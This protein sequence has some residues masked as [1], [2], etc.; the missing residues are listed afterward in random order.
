MQR[1]LLSGMFGFL[2]SVA[3]MRAA[4]GQESRP[5]T[6]EA[7]AVQQM[8]TRDPS[9]EYPKS[10]AAKEHLEQGKRA[11]GVGEYDKAIDSYTAAGLVDDAPLI[12]Y[13]L[14]QT[15]RAAKEYDKAIRQYR[16]FLDRGKP[17]AEVRALVD[18]HISTMKAELEHAASTAPPTG[19]V[20]D[21]PDG[22]APIDGI[23]PGPSDQD[24]TGGVWTSARKVA[25]GTGIV[26]GLAIGVGVV[27]GVQGR[28]YKDDAAQLCPSDP[29]SNAAEANALSDKSGDRARL[30]NISFGTGAALIVGATVVWFLGGPATHADGDH[31]VLVPQLGEGFTGLVYAQRF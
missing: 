26:G 30:A 24:A 15:Y 18:C 5:C 23:R 10:D 28:G 20:S 7:Q 3:G 8:S 9:L 31:A 13:D 27:F 11:F 12:L 29:C 14:G 21:D 22:V 4:T 16:L 2:V 6:K 19:P 25:L 17:G 1:T